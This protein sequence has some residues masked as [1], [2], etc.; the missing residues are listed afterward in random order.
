MT[1]LK[2]FTLLIVDDEEA[3]RNSIIF[4]FKRK[5]FTILSASNGTE[6]FELVKNNNIHLVISDIRMPCGDGI[7][8]LEKIREYNPDIP[9]VIFITG[10]TDSTEEECLAKGALKVFS[11]PYD[12][13]ALMNLVLETLGL[14]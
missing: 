13:K 9:T 3:L 7:S 8:L 14:R 6:A 12:R 1:D 5:G 11:K 10:F 2:K 4:D